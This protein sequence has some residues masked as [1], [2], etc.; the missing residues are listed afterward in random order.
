MGGKIWTDLLR[1]VKWWPIKYCKELGKATHW[2]TG[3]SVTLT[4][5]D[6]LLKCGEGIDYWRLLSVNVGP[7]S[8]ILPTPCATFS[9]INPSLFNFCQ[10]QNWW[11]V[12]SVFSLLE[13]SPLAECPTL[14]CSSSSTSLWGQS[15]QS[16][17]ADYISHIFIPLVLKAAIFALP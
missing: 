7:R 2:S 8:H 15:L 6:W 17:F 10:V 12:G 9:S 3:N 5:V 11:Q 16:W 4:V 13:V 14:V 1:I